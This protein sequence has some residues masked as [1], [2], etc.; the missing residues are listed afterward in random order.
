MNKVNNSLT[1]IKYSDLLILNLNLVFFSRILD[2][3]GF[4][5]MINL[6]HY[7]VMIVVFFLFHKIS[8]IKYYIFYSL[9]L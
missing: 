6:V 1:N 8:N 3:I 9:Y 7:V 2:R 4:P 5:G